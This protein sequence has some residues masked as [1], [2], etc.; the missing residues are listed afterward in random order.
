MEIVLIFGLPPFVSAVIAISVVYTL[1]IFICASNS[2]SEK[3]LNHLPIFIMECSNF[4]D[5]PVHRI[6]GDVQLFDTSATYRI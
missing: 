1:P 5:F 2:L 4:G 6:E 3:L